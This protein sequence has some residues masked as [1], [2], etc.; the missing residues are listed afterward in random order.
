[1]YRDVAALGTAGIPIFGDAAGY[2]LVDGYRTRLT[3]LTAA[4]AGSLPLAAL[5]RAAADLG[6]AHAAA[7]A[8]LKLTAALPAEL[9]EHAERVRRKFH[10]DAPGWYHDGDA[11]EHL[12]DVAGAV[13][14]QRVLDVTYSSWRQDFDCRLEPYGLVLKGGK[15]YLVARNDHGV[16]TFRVSSILRLA[17]TTDRFEWPTDFDL[18]AY[19]S[20]HVTEF[21][22][23]LHRGEAI[24]RFSPAALERLPNLM[25][26]AV[27]DAAAAGEQ[28][29]DGWVVATVPIESEDHAAAALLRLGAEAEVLEPASLRRRLAAT[30]AALAQIYRVGG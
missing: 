29:A 5:P 24:V 4:E 25:G 19:W 15:W 12:V 30:A 6:M 9:R 3:G 1:V 11:S 2:H 16:R 20:S 23:R 7:A 17:V 13:W 18:A 8:Q 22:A 26:P 28:Q 27:A 10:L 21:R 14:E